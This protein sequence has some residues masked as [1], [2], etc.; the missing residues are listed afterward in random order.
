[1]IVNEKM[2]K[3]LVLFF[4]VNFTTNLSAQT[5]NWDYFSFQGNSIRNQSYSNLGASI[6]GSNNVYSLERFDIAGSLPAHYRLAK[7]T[8]GALSHVSSNI[9]GS[10]YRAGLGFNHISTYLGATYIGG[11]QSANGIIYKFNSSLNHVLFKAII[12]SG[13]GSLNITGIVAKNNAVYIIGSINV[14]TTGAI[15]VDFGGSFSAFPVAASMNYMAKYDLS[16]NCIFV[17]SISGSTWF[18][19]DIEVDK[20]GNIYVSYFDNYNIILKKYNSLGIQDI[21]WGTKSNAVFSGQSNWVDVKLDPNEG[22]VYYVVDNSIRRY[23]T[24]TGGLIWVKQISNS[25]DVDISQIALNH[26]GVIYATGSAHVLVRTARRPPPKFFCV[27]SDKSVGGN[28]NFWASNGSAE[29]PGTGLVTGTDDKVRVVGYYKQGFAIDSYTA[30]SFT[31]PSGHQVS[32]GTFIGRV[33]DSRYNN[34]CTPAPLDLGA[35]RIICPNAPLQHLYLP[36]HAISGANA[37]IINWYF[38]GLPMWGVG[39]PYQQ[40]GGQYHS[41]SNI[42]GI[43]SVEII[44][45][46]CIDTL[47]DAMELIIKT[48]DCDVVPEVDVKISEC[49]VDFINNTTFGST[50]TLVSYFWDFGDGNTSTQPNPRHR[51]TVDGTYTVTLDIICYNSCGELCTVTHLVTIDVHGCE[52]HGEEE[53]EKREK[54]HKTSMIAIE[55]ELKVYPNPAANSITLNVLGYQE[56]EIMELKVYTIYGAEVYHNT[57]HQHKHSINVSEWSDGIYIL[58]L[59]LPDR[60]K[61]ITKMLKKQE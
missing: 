57:V 18:D 1:M 35:D 19:K 13:G 10:S 29:T 26:C 17:K 15:T 44:Y 9:P 23:N 54:E 12:P 47:K 20:R 34:C 55:K 53:L 32:E 14:P 60:N 3:C 41:S 28:I 25:L 48:P 16:G 38:N 2:I 11:Q 24:N 56:R 43:Y 61:V 52:N 31:V 51:Y 7:Y 27:G 58:K 6:D 46:N 4:L 21:A 40:L 39:S 8:N 45:P 50:T 5:A 22:S 59:F 42:A 36:N 37:P 49:D 30:P 33:D